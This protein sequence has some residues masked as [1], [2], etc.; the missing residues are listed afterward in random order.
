MTR[1]PMTI[2]YFING[3]EDGLLDLAMVLKSGTAK[4]GPELFQTD[5][6]TRIQQA[7]SGLDKSLIESNESLA[8][9][10]KYDVHNTFETDNTRNKYHQF[11]AF[12][13]R[14]SKVFRKI[15]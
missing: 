9:L 2:D 4:K 8:T 3:L 11:E 14:A 12:I 1:I 5:N 10:T 15:L 6:E 7:H 13:Q